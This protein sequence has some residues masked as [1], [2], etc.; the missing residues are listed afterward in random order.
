[1]E[2]L[3]DDLWTRSFSRTDLPFT[4]HTRGKVRD[5]YDLGDRYLMVAT[6][7]I[8]AFDHVLRP[9]I[10]GKGVILTQMSNFWFRH[11]G[12][13]ANHL[14]ETSFDHFPPQIREHDELRGRSAIVKKCEVIPIECV[15]RGYIIGSG[16]KDYCRSGTICG[17]RLPKD[18]QLAERLEEPIFTPATKA[19]EGHDENI[20]FETVVRVAGEDRAHAMRRIT[21]EIYEEASRYAADRGIIIA[22]TKIELGIDPER[23]D[24]LVWID[25]A[26]T[27]DSSRFWP[28]ETWQAGKNPESFDK[29]Y[30]RDYLESSDWDKQ[31]EPPVLPP[32]I[33]EGTVERYLEAWERLTGDESLRAG[34][35]SEL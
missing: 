35:I 19:A 18:L 1:M 12:T 3:R 20:P 11:F 22:D 16:W 21:L 31:S 29:Q 25:E 17:I 14:L 5:V 2:Q 15:A 24:E 4:L 32:E 33:I 13:V 8:S 28:A 23:P 34:V 27:P 7:R 30:V 6:D 9:G 26:L 10:P